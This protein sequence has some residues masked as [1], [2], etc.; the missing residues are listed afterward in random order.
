MEKSIE[1]FLNEEVKAYSLHVIRERALPCVIDGFKP[2][3]RKIIFTA[4]KVAH[5]FKKTSSFAGQVVFTANYD[6][7]DQQIPDTIARM[8]QDFPGSNNVPFL[9]GSGAFG[10]RF[11]PKAWAAPRYTSVKLSENFHDLF[12]DFEILSFTEQ[13]GDGFFEPDYFVPIIPTILLN[14]P[15]GIAVGFACEFQPHK[16]S[17]LIAR[18]RTIL[19]G[20]AIP[21]KKLSPFFQAFRGT[22]DWDKDTK[23]FVQS[24]LITF[25]DAKKG[26]N[27]SITELPTGTSREQ[28]I[29]RLD[30]M[31]ERDIITDYEDLCAKGQ[32]NFLVNVTFEQQM[33]LEEGKHHIIKVFGLV[34]NLNENMNCISENGKLLRFDSA[35]QLL[36]Y[37]VKFR[38][39]FLA[40]R[41]AYKI[42][43]FT[44]QYILLNE[45]L[46]FIKA[47]I[48]NEIK[49]NF[50]NKT[51]MKAALEK[52]GYLWVDKLMEIPVYLITVEQTDK[53]TTEL[54]DVQI[55]L[56][57]YKQ[58]TEKELYLKDLE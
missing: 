57:Y 58:V 26:F 2:S 5:T 21:V 1:Q 23:K 25:V 6:K 33:N 4:D 45:K 15:E 22:V 37:F 30:K 41:K 56:D 39:K 55:E 51:V 11:L 10:G 43:T 42:K 17:E 12:T 46:K 14:G 53:L 34:Q 20:K 50:K 47:V 8:V 54:M 24:G 29:E 16:K 3:Q 19:E 18:T 40:K 13:G 44:D 38:L 48:A 31:I 7:G 36:N 49:L 28:Y 9:D 52:L 35:D 27:Y 32:F